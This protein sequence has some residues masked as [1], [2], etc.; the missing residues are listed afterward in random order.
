LQGLS[1]RKRFGLLA[2]LAGLAFF[3]VRLRLLNAD[4]VRAPRISFGDTQ[5][6][7]LIA[8]QSLFSSKFWLA[9]K[10]FLIPLFFKIIGGDPDRIFAVQLYLSILCWLLFAVTCAV[11]FRAYPLKFLVP[12]V[13]LAFSL[14]EQVILWDSLVLSES[15]HF[16]LSAL[17]YASGLLLA[18][19]WNRW[20]AVIF[21]ALAALLAFARDTNASMFLFAGV[22]LLLLSVLFREHR[23]RLWLLGGSFTL[24]FLVATLF[25]SRGSHLYSAL[26]NVVT[27]RI[28]P[29]PAYTVYMQAQGM[30]V[31]YLNSPDVANLADWDGLSD[32]RL[33]DLRSWAKDRGSLA[34]VKFLWHFKADTL[35]K[36]LDDP[37]AVLAPDLHY[38]SSTGFKPVLEATAFAELL[39]PMRF[40]VVMFWLATL[41]AAFLTA[42]ALHQKRVTWLMPL[43]MILLAYPLIVLVWNTDPHDI[44]RHALPLNVQW[45][46]GLW[47]LLFLVA[48]DLLAHYSPLL[49][50]HVQRLMSQRKGTTDKPELSKNQ[51]NAAGG[52]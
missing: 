17:F 21:I 37:T 16:S 9:D 27:N 2:F 36:P 5:D 52:E 35:Q 30:P 11:V 6:Y 31:D 18:A 13:V 28:V 24:I 42:F 51:Q 43:L 10:P 38:Y 20:N 22:V 3:Y 7:L 4:T 25:A 50:E 34:L 19:R 41:A 47:L 23:R 49:A 45:R 32:P 14:T 40:G 44:Y 39:Y 12:A 29:N 8:S 26:L 33:S 46:L 1:N 15:L 48:D